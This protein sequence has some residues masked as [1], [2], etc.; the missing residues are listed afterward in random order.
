MAKLVL[1]LAAILIVVGIVWHG[2]T[3]ATFERIWHDMVERPDGPISFRFILQP[4]MAALVGVRQG[5][6]DGRTGRAPYFATMMFDR[7]ERVAHLREAVNATARIVLLGI[8]MDM[9]YQALVLK[10]F[11]P[12]EALII[13]L[14]LAF[15]PY[16]LVRGL[17]GRLARR[18]Y[19]PAQ[20][21]D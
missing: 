17:T 8:V 9:I 6:R 4:A 12:N 7:Q 5:L 15:V 10:T 16:I 14:M 2:V 20:T 3:I 1:L 18:W 13:A 19:A 21:H 11:Y